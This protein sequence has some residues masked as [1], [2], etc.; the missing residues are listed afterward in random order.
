MCTHMNDIIF[1]IKVSLWNEIEKKWIKNNINKKSYKKK[2][3]LP[4]NT[5][6]E[7]PNATSSPE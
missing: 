7:Y 4:P 1:L 5:T 3:D 6:C 2:K